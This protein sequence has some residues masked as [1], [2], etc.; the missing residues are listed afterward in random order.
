MRKFYYL[1]I[2]SLLVASGLT[3]FSGS[4]DSKDTASNYRV[5]EPWSVKAEV[6]SN[7]RVTEPWSV[8]DK[9]QA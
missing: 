7:Y 8:K 5:T 1:T 2:T 3:A 4:D 6:A 9:F